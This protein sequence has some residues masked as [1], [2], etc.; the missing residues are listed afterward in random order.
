MPIE[1]IA[2]WY[3]AIDRSE[4]MRFHK[5]IQFFLLRYQT[6]D[7][8]G[9]DHEVIEARRTRLDQAREILAFAHESRVVQRAKILFAGV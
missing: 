4:R 6:G 1:P 8:D 7:I 2:Y 3:T 9:H 5:F